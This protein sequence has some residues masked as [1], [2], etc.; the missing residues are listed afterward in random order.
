MSLSD[1]QSNGIEVCTEG[2]GP[3]L[4]GAADYRSWIEDEI[5]SAV[6][7]V[8]E[9]ILEAEIAAHL[10][11]APGERT[12]ARQGYRNGSYTRGLKTRVGALDITVPRDRDGSFRPGVFERYRRMESP[13]EEALLR[14]YLEGISTRRVGDIAEALGRG[15]PECLDGEP[16][17]WPPFGAAPG[18]AGAAALECVPVPLPGRHQPHGALGR[19][20]RAGKRAGGDRGQRGGIPRS[21]GL[22]GRLPRI[23]G[24]L[25]R[26]APGPG[27]A[28]TSGRA[29]RDQRCRSGG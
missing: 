11:A 8:L 17:E 9:E 14:A 1:M 13:L 25:A 21:A 7:A 29:A 27:A 28:W 19:R 5:R 15:G 18:V 6:K 12:E 3:H 16:A 4:F 24:E 23:G 20:Q 26:A 22:R 10:G 2:P